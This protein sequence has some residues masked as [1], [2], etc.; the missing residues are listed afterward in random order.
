MASDSHI[1]IR[2][3][4]LSGDYVD[5]Y[6]ENGAS[7]KEIRTM[8]ATYLQE[9]VYG[10]HVPVG[11]IGLMAVSDIVATPKENL[12]A[13][14]C[15][16]NLKPFILSEE[17]PALLDIA[18][19]T[20]VG[21]E[22]L[23]KNSKRTKPIRHARAEFTLANI[24][25][26]LMEKSGSIGAVERASGAVERECGAVERSGGDGTSHDSE[27]TRKKER[28]LPKDNPAAKKEDKK[29]NKN[30]E[31]SSCFWNGIDCTIRVPIRCKNDED[32][33]QQQPQPPRPNF[34]V[35]AFFVSTSLAQ[36]FSK[37]HA[38]R[39]FYIALMDSIAENPTCE[40]SWAA[41]M[42]QN[43]IENA[44]GNEAHEIPRP[45][46]NEYNPAYHFESGFV[47]K[48]RKR[49][50]DLEWFSVKCWRE[51]AFL[52]D[53]QEDWGDLLLSLIGRPGLEQ[54]CL[55]LIRR[56]ELLYIGMDSDQNQ[57][58]GHNPLLKITDDTCDRNALMVGLVHRF[59]YD[60][61]S[62][63]MPFCT[64]SRA[65]EKLMLELLSHP[66]LITPEVLHHIDAN[67]FTPLRIAVE[68]CSDEICL[69]IL[70]HPC[71]TGTSDSSQ[72]NSST[73]SG[74]E[75]IKI[76]TLNR[77][78]GFGSS[79]LQNAIR[80]RG[81]WEVQ[82]GTRF[83]HMN[84]V[85]PN[86]AIRSCGGPPSG[87]WKDESVLDKTLPQWQSNAV[88]LE[89]LKSFPDILAAEVVNGGGNYH[90]G[91]LG[92]LDYLD[93]EIGSQPKW[94]Q[95]PMGCIDESRSLACE[96][97]K[98]HS[99]FLGSEERGGGLRRL[100]GRGWYN[101]YNYP[102]ANFS[103]SIGGLEK[104]PTEYSGEELVKPPLILALEH[105]NTTVALAIMRHE[106]FDALKYIFDRAESAVDVIAGSG[107]S[108]SSEENSDC[109][110][111]SEDTIPNVFD[112]YIEL[113]GDENSASSEASDSV[114][115]TADESEDLALSSS[116]TDFE[117]YTKGTTDAD[118]A[119]LTERSNFIV[120][121]ENFREVYQHN[122]DKHDILR[123]KLTLSHHLSLR[124]KNS[125]APDEDTIEELIN[126]EFAEQIY[127]NSLAR[128]LQGF[129]WD[130][131]AIGTNKTLN[132]N[133][134]NPT[135]HLRYNGIKLAQ[136]PPHLRYNGTNFAQ[137]PN[138]Q[139]SLRPDGRW[140]FTDF[141][142]GT[143]GISVE[144]AI[145]G[146]SLS[147]EYWSLDGDRTDGGDVN[148]I[149]PMANTEVSSG[150]SKSHGEFES[151]AGM[152]DRITESFSMEE[153]IGFYYR[154]GRFKD[155]F[156]DE[157]SPAKSQTQAA[158]QQDLV[159]TRELLKETWREV[160]E[161][162]IRKLRDCIVKKKATGKN[163][164][165]RKEKSQRNSKEAASS[166]VDHV[167]ESDASSDAKRRKLGVTQGE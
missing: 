20:I 39:R 97:P 164:W 78:D 50:W 45:Q 87:G 17:E 33:P 153:L 166:D 38:T 80:F 88:A 117:N 163:L 107:T 22:K 125:L 25:I 56:N 106:L 134:K 72:T 77:R 54:V 145:F 89:V 76:S 24:R 14:D 83:A 61:G 146:H 2:F 122:F 10:H 143:I 100:V 23:R 156:C 29:D 162:A 7:I 79:I 139:Y 64:N 165:L 52:A 49:Q 129:V 85:S 43:E 16:K 26:K 115:N 114:S 150:W 126:T 108:G 1:L 4:F 59:R 142:S 147:R 130:E 127:F 70:N 96:F 37:P 110:E 128:S 135:Q 123:D 113:V 98:L 161:N 66:T 74:A 55:D 92:E 42:D 48:P 9:N 3:W 28:L 101:Y 159:S 144:Q 46:A 12:A 102:M 103:G 119:C 36:Y 84:D 71:F 60:N 140:A 158:A 111:E 31:Q 105:Q 138:L 19:V 65:H 27:S 157:N 95:L 6:V 148:E 132:N 53:V 51:I 13:D 41:G 73:D 93:F 57:N 99:A 47:D 131:K 104:S 62:V 155:R 152:D 82:N 32:D 116:D 11:L 94:N 58:I 30:E 141:K 149:L 69:R 35:R 121:T 133:M 151:W 75:S 154:D 8:A 18:A 167:V 67:G 81:G 112:N 160:K 86:A 136:N 15:T 124:N 109:D 40:Y 68:H 91:K 21:Q 44:M 118:L 63:T 120:R 34:E 137:N 5:S 90:Y